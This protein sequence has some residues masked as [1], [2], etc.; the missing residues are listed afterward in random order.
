MTQRLGNEY[1]T[2]IGIEQRV[3]TNTNLDQLHPSIT[4]LIGGGYVVVWDSQATAGDTGGSG[5]T[6]QL[7][8]E[9]GNKLGTEFKVNTYTT[10]NQFTPKVAALADG[11]FAVT[12]AGASSADGWGISVQVYDA[13]GNAVGSQINVNTGITNTQ[14][15]PDI[16]GLD[17]GGFIVI[18]ESLAHWS[19]DDSGIVAQ[20]Y[21][22][23]YAP[24]GSNFE[25]KNT[26]NGGGTSYQY[27]PSVTKL[28]DGNLLVV[29]K[30]QNTPGDDDGISAQLL[31]QSGSFV[32]SE[33]KI[34]ANTLGVDWS[35]NVTSLA[36]GFVAV[37][38]NS[39]SGD[40]AMRLFN[41]NGTAITGDIQVNTYDGTGDPCPE[42]VALNDGGFV[43]F[44]L[45]N[46]A[47]DFITGDS[48][49][50][51]GQRYDA[52]GNLMG[53]EFLVNSFGEVASDSVRPMLSATLTEGGEL[54]VAWSS[55]GTPNDALG[56]NDGSRTG[57]SLQKFDPNALVNTEWQWVGNE[58]LSP[59]GSEIRVNIGSAGHQYTPT[60]TT[61]SNG[62]YI[63]AWQT[64]DNT[65]DVGTGAGIS[66]Q[67]YD[68]NGNAIGGEFSINN[69]KTNSQE[70][71]DIIA[72]KNGGFVVVWAGE[73]AADSLWGIAARVF[74]N[75]G[76][77]ISSDIAVNTVTAGT[78]QFPAVTALD[79][80][81]FLVAWN[82]TTL[83]IKGQAFASD[84]SA[85]GSEFTIHA[86]TVPSGVYDVSLDQTENGNI[87][88]T[89]RDE[90]A[91]GDPQGSGITGQVIQGDGTLIGS[92]FLV[93]TTT[94]SNDDTP[95]VKALLGG[96][97]AVSW[98]HHSDSIYTRIFNESG[99]PLTS[100]TFVNE[101][102]LGAQQYMPSI[103]PTLDGGY[104]V[105]W[106][107]G[108]APDPFWQ[109]SHGI[110]G[111]KF[112]ASG[113]KVDETFIVNSYTISGGS[114][115]PG[116]PTA[117]L[118]YETGIVTVTWHSLGA[119]TNGVAGDGS[120]YG[121]SA[122]RFQLSCTDNV[123]RLGTSGA[124]VFSPW[125]GHDSISG[126]AGNDTLDGGLC[127]DTLHGGDDNDSLLGGEG[128][129]L[130]NGDAG[131]DV[132]YG[133]NGADALNGG[134][135]DD[136][137]YGEAGNDTLDGGGDNDTLN[138]G[139]GND[140]LLGGASG[141]DSLLGGDGDD[142][143]DG[144]SNHDI[145]YGGSGNDMLYGGITGNDT[146]YGE[147]GDDLLQ[148][149][150]SQDVLDGGADNDTLL[151][152]DGNDTLIGGAGND[153]LMGGETGTD[154]LSGGDG[155]DLLNGESNNDTL[156]GGNDNDT[157]Y[158]GISG[159]DTLYGEAGD[160]YLSGE[161][162]HDALDGGAGNDTLTGGEGSDTLTG[163]DGADVLTGDSNADRFVY[164][165]LSESSAG[166]SDL[167]TDFAQGLDVIDLAALGFSG[168]Q[169]G[170]A[171]GTVLGYSFSGGNTVVTADGSTFS[172][173]LTGET[174]LANSDFIFV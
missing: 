74:D 108:S 137:L 12:W 139:A 92:H 88:V 130:L 168:I 116:Q 122:Q 120:G 28:S 100:E 64:D 33:F 47:A 165:A 15:V 103:L 44:W 158:G 67:L 89:W 13:S 60:I 94:N 98:R 50:I 172:F 167:L 71:P 79:N 5:I 66:G 62:N 105:F 173:E 170:A 45:A 78:Q 11:G 95:Y 6:G 138:G 38:E 2:P 22:D 39:N 136:T 157:L 150:T 107:S 19:Q 73:T 80:G 27:Q 56:P 70:N 1:T 102:V 9:N 63:I 147:A 164:T 26:N 159:M 58:N 106:H 37:W 77:A 34:N 115:I 55:W 21:D 148:G 51:S 29:W 10:S 53:G 169:S 32:G 125:F 86:D 149:G 54:V 43:V 16:I 155:N 76:T 57:I 174:A 4:Y 18:W 127:N 140:S 156:Y 152:G 162:N 91:P 35:P 133:G 17:D 113:N 42:V 118:N 160:D 114:T 48:L 131:Q 69:Y 129:D 134:A 104:Y 87:L 84:G 61:L 119:P 52:S 163:G 145:L 123:A 82:S 8:D 161:S 81:G 135:G 146:L 141:M 65:L 151:G 144:E 96:N 117:T 111:Q 85:A 101:L 143:I 46:K 93:N 110:A 121:I 142:I 72:L 30:S 83:G 36:N 90:N 59:I 128:N 166:A 14:S 75:N 112:D 97:F 25:I 31:S 49:S 68:P 171:S 24:V 7:Y 109:A 23:T 40:V 41:N 154:S 124:D 132:L 3:N 153:S 126:F 20:I 99:T